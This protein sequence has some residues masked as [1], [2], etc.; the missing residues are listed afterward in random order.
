MSSQQ[1]GSHAAATPQQIVPAT[2]KLG[3]MIPGMG[4][5]ATTLIAGVEAVRQR[6]RQADRLANA[7]GHDSPGQAY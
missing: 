4:A 5:V 2:G 6:I 7:D 1:E 3:V